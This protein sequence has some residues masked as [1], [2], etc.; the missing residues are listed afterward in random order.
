MTASSNS[1]EN[2]VPVDL[3]LA[4]DFTV[5]GV[6]RPVEVKATA[7]YIKK[8]EDT[9]ARHPG[10]MLHVTATFDVYLSQHNIKRPKFIILK[11]DDLQKIELDFYASTA[12]PEAEEI[13]Q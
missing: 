3:T 8:S 6:T 12:L 13:T 7:V 11:L 4:G 9:G 5:H 1:L 10:D 2:N